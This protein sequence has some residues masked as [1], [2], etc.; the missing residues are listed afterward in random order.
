MLRETGKQKIG[1][2]NGLDN[3]KKR[4]IGER[5]DGRYYTMKNDQGITLDGYRLIEL[6]KAQ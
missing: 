4:V 6:T 2:T 5:V 1:L 3:M